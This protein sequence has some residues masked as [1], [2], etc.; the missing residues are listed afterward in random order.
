MK[1]GWDNT[2]TIHRVLEGNTQIAKQQNKTHHATIQIV[3]F[4]KKFFIFY[5]AE[6]N[7][8]GFQVVIFILNGL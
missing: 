3:I 7:D 1:I 8:P 4:R 6:I 2:A 5:S